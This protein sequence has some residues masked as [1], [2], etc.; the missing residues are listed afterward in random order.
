MCKLA[1]ICMEF[2]ATDCYDL[3]ETAHG[4]LLLL[5]YYDEEA[6]WQLKRAIGLMH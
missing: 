3:I 1:L 5:P 2:P 4:M 6:R